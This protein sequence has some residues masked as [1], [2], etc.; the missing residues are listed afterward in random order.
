MIDILIPTLGRAEVLEPLLQNIRET[1]PKASYV[2][3]FV[4]DNEDRESHKVLI[5]SATAIKPADDFAAILCDGTYPTKINAGY[6]A[7]RRRAARRVA[8][9]SAQF[10]LPTADDVVF[11][12]GWL[13]A[14]LPVFEDPAVQ[15]VG[16][17]DLSPAT[18]DRT[19]ATMPVLRRSYVEHP[20]AALDELA[21]VF[22]EGYQH[23]FCETETW[24]LASHRGVTAWAEGA[25]IEHLHP[26]WGKRDE[27]ATDE[28]GN[29]QG[30]EADEALFRSRREQW[31]RSP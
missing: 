3:W 9:E 1:T 16:T 28:K 23:N 31:L 17:D 21:T 19:H 8:A 15:V 20:G 26:A 14:A 4:L 25:V 11:H 2:A 6:H 13:E 27:D 22:H 29:K 30:W 10:V 5:E 18:A 24:Q 12:D 7:T